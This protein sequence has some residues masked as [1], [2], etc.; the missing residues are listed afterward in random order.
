MGN[1]LLHMQ[2]LCKTSVLAPLIR[3]TI[4]QLQIPGSPSVKISGIVALSIYLLFLLPLS[5]YNTSNTFILTPQLNKKLTYINIYL[6]LN[7]FR[8]PFAILAPISQ[9]LLIATAT[10][11]FIVF[12]SLSIKQPV[13]AYS[14]ERPL[15][16]MISSVAFACLIRVCQ[17]IQNGE[18]QSILLQLV[19]MITFVCLIDWIS[20]FRV[21][22]ILE[23]PRPTVHQIKI[24]V[25][26][27]SNIKEYFEKLEYFIIRHHR[28]CCNPECTCSL[29]IAEI[30][31][32]GKVEGE[33]DDN[34]WYQFL[35]DY[36]EQYYSLSEME[37]LA[38]SEMKSRI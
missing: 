5:L 27:I 37:T 16:G 38:E 1:I 30:T 14:H 2:M 25:F 13:F 18:Q 9:P 33:Y 7:L 6:L 22:K 12:I 31:S 34:I 35:I 17:A 10:L 29:V 26:L 21:R 3:A 28:R 23:L 24:L 8:V 32:K 19:G 4:V 36:I 11:F 20:Q 15:K